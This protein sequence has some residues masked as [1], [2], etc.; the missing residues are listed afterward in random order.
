MYGVSMEKYWWILMLTCVC[1]V[2]ILTWVIRVLFVTDSPAQFCGRE[3]VAR[4][5]VV[6]FSA[7]PRRL[8]V[9]RSMLYPRI[10]ALFF[11]KQKAVGENFSSQHFQDDGSSNLDGMASQ[12][13]SEGSSS[14]LWP[15]ILYCGASKNYQTSSRR[16]GTLAS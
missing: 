12:F 15:S 6:R 2:S 5:S 16:D 3:V 8:C 14:G 4:P 1:R 11:K 7:K 10:T 13:I 9:K